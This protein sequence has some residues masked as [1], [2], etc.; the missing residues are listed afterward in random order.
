MTR[1]AINL[2]SVRD[3]DEPT[4]AI[5]DRVADAGYAGVQFSGGVEGDVDA[6]RRTLADRG[7]DATPA[8]VDI[9]DLE[10]D[11]A[12]TL[13][14][15]DELGCGGVVVPWLPP[16]DFADESAVS[17]TVDRLAA[18]ADRVR[19]AGFSFHYHN[20][21]QEF[22]SVGTTTG[23]DRL[24]AETDCCIE[25]DVGWAAVGDRDPAALLETIGD[26]GP[27]VHLKD[28][29]VESGTPVEIGTGDVDMWACAD[30]ARDAGA[31]WLIYE[32]DHPE[33]PVESI[34]HGAQFLASL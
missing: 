31:E 29:E 12:E 26:R 2:Y 28:V 18:L 3:L 6:I 33:D 9:D 16:E 1:T 20:H 30:A 4:T 21:D 13:A 14:R 24:L 10:A 23:F 32:H 8:H 7:L 15:Y 34:E 25:L 22:Q 5:L 11:L 19:S 27:L 17:G